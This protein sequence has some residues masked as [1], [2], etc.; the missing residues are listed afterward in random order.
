MEAAVSEAAGTDMHAWFEKYV[1]G[2]EPPPFADAL[3]RVGMRYTAHGEGAERTYVVEE[4]SA[5]TAAQRA[6]R[7]QWLTGTSSVGRLP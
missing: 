5:A 7:E 6:L 2:T 1:G 4:D 3:A